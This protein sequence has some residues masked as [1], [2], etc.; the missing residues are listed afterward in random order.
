M[1]CF[2]I[3]NYHEPNVD[4]LICQLEQALETWNQVE[5]EI[6]NL[7]PI[8]SNIMN[9][10]V[11]DGTMLNIINQSVL[12]RKFLIVGDS[13]ALGYSQSG[14]L[15]TPFPTYISA[16]S[17]ISVE[18]VA[19]SGAGFA[20]IGTGAGE[21]KNFLATL[22]SYT[23]EKNEITDII[24]AG[25][26]NDRTHNS[27]EITNAV[28]KFY[29]YATEN[30][31]NAKIS[32]AFIGWS[33]FPTEY[34]SLRATAQVYSQCGLYGMGVIGGTENVLHQVSFFDSDG[35]HPNTLGQI[36]IAVYIASFLRGGNADVFKD[37]GA[38][39]FPEYNGVAFPTIYTT[40]HNDNI[41]IYT[42]GKAVLDMS[43]FASSTWADNFLQITGKLA[44]SPFRGF[45]TCVMTNVC[46][47]RKSTDTDYQC[48]P[49][50]IRITDGIAY[51][52]L[53]AYD[54]GVAYTG[55]LKDII[56]PAFSTVIDSILS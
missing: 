28:K 49:C 3:G 24:V 19:T 29:A 30:F 46:L 7:E 5:G 33:L 42:Q 9:Q 18:C 14:T 31:P 50:T 10:Y 43:A 55:Q 47:Y 37:L 22:Q 38:L 34:E 35:I 56:I 8:V 6:N 26:Y 13:Y 16:N 2:N 4:W 41:I 11:S 51:L 54:N 53:L 44:D 27:P 12:N 52:Q 36:A 20:N 25:G 23:G 48:A 21:G 1:G 15:Y 32:V 39:N 17:N 40:Q 45:F